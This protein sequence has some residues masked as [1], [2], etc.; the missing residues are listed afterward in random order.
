MESLCTIPIYVPIIAFVANL[1]ICVLNKDN[2]WL[3]PTVAFV[4][5]IGKTVYDIIKLTPGKDILEQCNNYFSIAQ[6]NQNLHTIYIPLF[7]YCLL[8]TII[9]SYI[10]RR[11]KRVRKMKL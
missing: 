4:F 10:L 3:I 7:L 6:C 2:L 8:F 1:L 5:G 9:F 11:N